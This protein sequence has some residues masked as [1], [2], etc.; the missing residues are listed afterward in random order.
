MINIFK[1]MAA[2]DFFTI[3]STYTFIVLFE[4]MILTSIYNF[5]VF[6]VDCFTTDFVVHDKIHITF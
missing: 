2:L 4:T 3:L 5:S 6:I 1:L